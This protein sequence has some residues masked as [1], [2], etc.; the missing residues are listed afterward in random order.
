M[1]KNVVITENGQGKKFTVKRIRTTTDTGGVCDWFPEDEMGEKTITSNGTYR[2]VDE[3]LFGYSEVEVDIPSPGGGDFTE[4]YAYENGTYRARSEGYDGYNK[5]TVDVSSIS[6]EMDDGSEYPND[7]IIEMER[8]P[9]TGELSFP[10]EPDPVTGDPV[11]VTKKIP[12]KIKI[13]TLPSKLEYR[14]GET[15]YLTGAVV[16]AYDG[17]DNLFTDSTY[18]DGVI[19]NSELEVAPLTVSYDAA[20]DA[21]GEII[22]E[23]DLSYYKGNGTNSYEKIATYREEDFLISADEGVRAVIF[24]K[25]TTENAMV[26]FAIMKNSFSYVGFTT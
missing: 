4:L 14:T 25:T 9:D 20:V 18:T 3:G 24:R 8:D 16:K 23:G 12:S 17:N 13:E 19:P 11:I 10:T 1:S 26:F 21:G 2:A 5:V 22:E 15:V 7:Y 6:G